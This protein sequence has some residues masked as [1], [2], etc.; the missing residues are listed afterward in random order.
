MTEE[1]DGVD[2]SINRQIDAK[3]NEPRNLNHEVTV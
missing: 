2:R 3:R 1:C